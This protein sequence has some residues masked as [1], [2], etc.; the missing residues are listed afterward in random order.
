[1]LKNQFDQDE[2]RKNFTFNTTCWFCSKSHANI[3]HH[4]LGR[5]SNSILNA[6][7][8]ENQECHLKYH[9]RHLLKENQIA[10]LKKTYDYLMDQGYKLKKKDK[11]FIEKNIELYKHIL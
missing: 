3:F 7:P 4:I 9:P 6:A 2:L 10:L 1:M 5:S 8:M 11:E